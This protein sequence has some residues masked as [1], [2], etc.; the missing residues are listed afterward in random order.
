MIKNTLPD[1]SGNLKA[2]KKNR[3]SSKAFDVHSWRGFAEGVLRLL[4]LQFCDSG[5]Q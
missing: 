4:Y 3:N 1:K 2:S 5:D